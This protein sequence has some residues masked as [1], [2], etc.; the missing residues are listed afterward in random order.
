MK[1]LFIWIILIQNEGTQNLNQVIIYIL[2]ENRGIRGNENIF[3]K[4]NN[5]IKY[6]FYKI[7]N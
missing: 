5:K 2:N 3:S 6:Y 1:K 4:D 7:E